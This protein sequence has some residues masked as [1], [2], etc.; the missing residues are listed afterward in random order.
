MRMTGL[1]AACLM[2]TGCWESD[3]AL[4]AKS[5]S[6]DPFMYHGF[7]QATV[8]GHGPFINNDKKTIVFA[9]VKGGGYVDYRA[10][11]DQNDPRYFYFRKI[12]FTRQDACRLY[13]ELEVEGPGGSAHCETQAFE[14]RIEKILSTNPYYVM[15]QKGSRFQY[16]V[17]LNFDPSDDRYFVI[18]FEGPG[19]GRITSLAE[20]DYVSAIIGYV[21]DLGNPDL[22]AR[23]VTLRNLSYLKP[24]HAKER[25][26]TAGTL[27][28][29]PSAPA[30][31][32]RIVDHEPSQEE[33]AWAMSRAVFGA[34]TPSI[35]KIGSCSKSQPYV[36]LCR[37]RYVTENQGWFTNN[38]GVWSFRRAN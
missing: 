3:R 31:P 9:P 4:F 19:S 17:F 7:Y 18:L 5:G 15:I 35:R 12:N 8:Q 33:M 11:L 30:P 22:P 6:D 26:R 24:A 28:P 20:I 16:G 23:S 25:V 34:D 37:Y 38:D 14:D 29:A 13:V 10:Y 27:T 32:R 36:Y 2:T 21:E 1:V